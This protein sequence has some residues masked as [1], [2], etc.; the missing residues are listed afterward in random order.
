MMPC[1]CGAGLEIEGE[2]I[3]VFQFECLAKRESICFT[4]KHFMQ[5]GGAQSHERLRLAAKTK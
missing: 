5:S 3:R 1:P 2:M 4:M